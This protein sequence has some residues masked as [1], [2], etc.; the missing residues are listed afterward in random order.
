VQIPE[1]RYAKSGSISLAYQ[2]AG[3]GPFDVVLVPGLSHFE[4]AW[5]MANHHG[6]IARRLAS[7]ATGL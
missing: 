2:V 6:E 4:L 3:D 1:M 7:F 5:T